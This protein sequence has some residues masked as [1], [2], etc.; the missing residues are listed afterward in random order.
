MPATSR[1]LEAKV[2]V[3]LVEAGGRAVE[4]NIVLPVVPTG[5]MVGVKPLFSGRSLGEGENATFDVALV[6]PD[7][8][9]LTGQGLR[10]ELLKIESRY[11]Y[12][13]RDGRWEYEP[14]KSTRRIADGKI[15]VAPDKPGRITA[16]VQW[17]RY[18]LEVSSADA[19]G[20][21]T[22]IGFDAGWYT[23]ASADT[24][25][26]LEIALDK[27]EYK[28]GEQMTVAVVARTAGR[29]TLNVM[30]DKLLSSITQEVKPGTASIKIPVGSDWGTGAYV[31]ATLRRPLDAQEQ[32]MPGRA[33][34]RAMVL[35]RSQGAHAGARHETAGAA[36][37]E[38][39]L[40]RADQD[41]RPR[42]AD[43]AR[44]VVA[45]V[46]VG[47]LNLTNYKPPAPDEYYLGQ[48]Q[49]SAELRDLYG[50]LIDG[51]QGTRG[52]IRTGGDAG[53]ELN[54]SP[55]TQAPLALF[56][57]IVEVRSGQAEVAFDIPAFAGTVRV[58]AVA[59]SKDK[60][61]RASGDVTVRDPVVLTATL[62]RFLLT[63]DK[64]SMNLDLDNVEG[65][66]GAYNLTVTAEGP[67][68]IGE[69]AA[70][71][72]QLR[73]KQRDRVVVPLNASGAGPATVKVAIKGPGD[74]ALER[75]Y[76]MN[77]KPATQVLAR[78]TVK[79]IAKGESL[80]LS[81]DLFADLVPGTGKVSVSVGVS[82]A[83]DAA[84]LLKA[85]DRYPYGCSEQITSRAMPLLYVNELASAAHL[86]LDDAI[87]QRI[88]D[89]IDRVLARQSSNGS[90]GLWGVGGDD[91]W[92]DAYVTDFLTRAQGARL[93]GAGHGVQAGAR[94][95]PQHRRHGGGRVEGRRPQSRLRALCA[96]A[97]RHG[98]ARRSALS[99]RRQARRSRHAD[100]Q[101]A[102]RRGAGPAR[103]PHPR[104]AG[105]Q[106]RARRSQAAGAARAVQPRGLRLDA[107]ATPPRW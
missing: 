95:A 28:P 31:V 60:V 30:G 54:G 73:A 34:R 57:G 61:G 19:D 92:L 72:L 71:S 35:D 16:P 68:A 55:P 22:S 107:C 66:A 67:V 58:M 82:T 40:A 42:L 76:V 41:R 89:A 46:D 100:R 14:I 75:S 21:T 51:M 104:R 52:Q 39:D 65:A 18:R 37:A 79:P 77:V 7:G 8:K 69:G 96:G 84:S 49:L 62:P 23:E 25:D 17:G 4:K 5:N 93:R 56:S 3:R 27:P 83:L 20:P 86:A 102:D 87:D 63:G 64:S 50:Q 98:A 70:K 11:Q 1:P 44:V 88:R 99:R 36:A 45:A 90:F 26:M 29:V 91:A 13:R 24:P 9:M 103:R 32:R 47:I 15:D 81:S 97:E 105:L 12:Y 10:Y 80:T 33:H 2:I 94:P 48:R 78:R 101:G 6:A 38:H 59:W 53:A 43:Q 85:L 106:G 74:F